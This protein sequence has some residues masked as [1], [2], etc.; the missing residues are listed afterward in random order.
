MDEL[1][2]HTKQQLIELV[3]ELLNEL[4]YLRTERDRVNEKNNKLQSEIRIKN[5]EI[6]TLE[7][8]I[9]TEKKSSQVEVLSTLK[10][11]RFL[12]ETFSFDT[13]THRQKEN[14]SE[15]YCMMLRAKEEVI[16]KKLS[17]DIYLPF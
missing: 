11:A 4:D 16:I 17:R 1:K 5:S 15:R 3:N 9:D 10:T 12:L 8:R 6:S 13:F 14:L 7:A 2:K